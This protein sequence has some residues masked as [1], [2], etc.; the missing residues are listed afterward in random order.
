[1]RS[2]LALSLAM[3]ACFGMPGDEGGP[4]HGTWLVDP[5][6]IEDW[7][8]TRGGTSS[9]TEPAYFSPLPAQVVVE[10]GGVLSWP[11]MEH[12]GVVDGA[13]IRVPPATEGGVERAVST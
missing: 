10:S 4:A 5:D 1:M 8:C 3:G 2:V 11:V 12:S 6:P 9:C 7:F 13:C